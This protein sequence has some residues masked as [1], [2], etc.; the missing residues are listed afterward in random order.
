MNNKRTLALILTALLAAS[1]VSCGESETTTDVSGENT[2]TSVQEYS[3]EETPDNLPALDFKGAAV[4]I[5]HRGD[6]KTTLLE[7]AGEESGDVVNDAVFARNRSEA[8]DNCR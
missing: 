1:I 4:R 7:I 2:S 5:H 6:D 8:G 3:R